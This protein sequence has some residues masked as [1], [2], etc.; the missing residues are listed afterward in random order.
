[1][2]ILKQLMLGLLIASSVNISV[3]AMEAEDTDDN[4]QES[5]E[6]IIK[7]PTDS[8][9]GQPNEILLHICAQIISDLDLNNYKQLHEAIKRLYILKA[10]CRRF[11]NL[12]TDQEIARILVDNGLNILS[13]SKGEYKIALFH[14]AVINGNSKVVKILI[15]TLP[16]DQR[17]NLIMAKHNDDTLLHK[18]GFF[19]H[20]EVAKTLLEALSVTQRLDLMT[21]AGKYCGL[22][23]HGAAHYGHTELVRVYLE[24]LP[25]S[26]QSTLITTTNMFGE[27]A[28]HEAVNSHQTEVVKLLVNHYI[29]L[30]IKIPK[31]LSHVLN[32][33]EIELPESSF[34]TKLKFRF[35]F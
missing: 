23:W 33:F 21:A 28:L 27:T 18:L 34:E 30:E 5:T 6:Q 4:H 25:K 35:K 8:L 10:T 32:K 1:M 22:A 13:V 29:Q 2:K 12:L 16:E 19:G 31:D 17:T 15:E 20:A 14:E 9:M 24:A 26:H 7:Y 11:R 3:F